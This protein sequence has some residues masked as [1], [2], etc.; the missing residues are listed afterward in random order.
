M[1]PNFL[2]IKG[3]AEMGKDHSILGIAYCKPRGYARVC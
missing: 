1:E 2:E 3:D